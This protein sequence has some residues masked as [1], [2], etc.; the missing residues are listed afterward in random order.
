[1]RT[2]TGEPLWQEFIPESDMTIEEV[3]KVIE[4][5]QCFG[6]EFKVENGVLYYK[7]K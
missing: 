4:D 2:K 1:M 3:I 5:A 6:F 7:E